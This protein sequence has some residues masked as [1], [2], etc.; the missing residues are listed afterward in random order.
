MAELS[1][2]ARR[3]FA[4]FSISVSFLCSAVCQSILIE[5]FSEPLLQFSFAANIFD[6]LPLFAL[7]QK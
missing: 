2:R 3:G 1:E 6:S 7:C 4:L 5:S